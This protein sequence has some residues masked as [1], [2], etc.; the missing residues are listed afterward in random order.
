MNMILGQPQRYTAEGHYIL[1]GNNE[2][3][4]GTL[5]L[6]PTGLFY[7]GITDFKT[8]GSQSP[9]RVIG[10]RFADDGALALLKLPKSPS[11]YPILW[12]AR[13][14][15]ALSR[16][17]SGEEPGCL[18]GTYNGVWGTAEGAPLDMLR[19]ILADTIDSELD[20][21]DQLDLAKLERVFFERNVLDEMERVAKQ[22]KQIGQL[23]IR[24]WPL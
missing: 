14:N 17:L 18:T 16:K 10:M 1:R 3:Q 6:L 21:V 7:G 22:Q 5:F 13:P 9:K 8:D 2:T 11:L 20:C 15:K 24:D 4:R 19:P 23:R 12:Y